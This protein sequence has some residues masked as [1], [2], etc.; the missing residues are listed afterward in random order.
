MT[1]EMRAGLPPGGRGAVALVHSD[2]SDG[3]VVLTSGPL[4]RPETLQAQAYEQLKAAIIAGEMEAGRLYSVNQF[5]A[6]LG[7]SRT[8]VREALLVLEQQGILSMDRN[9]GFRVLALTSADL[10]EIIGLRRLLEIPAMEQLAAMSP[11]PIDTLLQARRIY[12]DLQRAA[13]D[14]DLLTFLALDRR[15]HLTLVDALG[16]A[17]LT[18]LVGELRDHMYLPGLRRISESRQ[19][20]GQGPEHL[21]LLTA[22]ENGDASGA[23][24]VMLAHLERTQADWA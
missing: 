9:R 10:A 2:S 23:G 24:A 11:S 21:M 17:R 18:R 6:L 3:S 19:L 1:S 15:F 8:P 13:D 5:A 20:H 7:V 22:I 16:N 14:D 4:A 12:A